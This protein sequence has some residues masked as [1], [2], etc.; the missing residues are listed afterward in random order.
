M[1]FQVEGQR[2]FVLGDDAMISMRHAYFLAHGQGL[3]WNPGQRVEGFTNLGWTL[4]MAAVHGLPL[5]LRL[6]SL[7]VQLIN[8]ALHLVLTAYVYR[9]VRVRVGEWPALGAALLVGLDA[10]LLA[11]GLGGFETSLQTLLVTVALLRFVPVSGTSSDH[12]SQAGL[13]WVP[14]WCALAFFVRPDAV[15]L[16]VTGS[17]AALWVAGNNRRERQAVLWSVVGGVLLIIGI[18]AFQKWYYGYWFPNTYYLKASA[19]TRQFGRGLKYIAKFVLQ[20]FHMA[21]VLA[22]LVYL[23]SGLRQAKTRRDYLPAALILAAWVCYIVWVGGDVFYLSRFWAPIIPMLAV[24]TVLLLCRWQREAPSS[25]WKKGAAAVLI[26]LLGLQLV[27]GLF[28][29]RS[30]AG[31]SRSSVQYAVALGHAHLPPGTTIGVFLAGTTPYFMPDTRFH[32]LL[33][34]CDTHIAHSPAHW[35]PPGHNKWDF[36]YS[37]DVVKPRYIITDGEY[38]TAD[39]A[40]TDKAMRRLVSLRK[41]YGFHPSL[42]LNPLF[43][44]DYVKTTYSVDG[45]QVHGQDIY[46]RKS[47]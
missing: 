24:C 41:D 25:P 20:E 7:V 18:L 2:Y 43:R 13:R 19:D 33:G 22:P 23:V 37:L 28:R 5:P 31:G 36:A 3:V 16:F 34:K 38:P 8:L 46:V 29:V 12:L 26:M 14:L 32:D 9:F 17:A 30:A 35:G 27:G 47:P 21:F 45:E 42:W 11:Y 4:I 15:T 6:M 40:A 44:K 10:P 39:L 1:S